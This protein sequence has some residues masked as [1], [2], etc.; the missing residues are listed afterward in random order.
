MD[1]VSDVSQNC[2]G[3]TGTQALTFTLAKGAWKY[4]FFAKI[5][6]RFRDVKIEFFG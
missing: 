6:V 5:H 2:Y 1:F 4:I 3:F